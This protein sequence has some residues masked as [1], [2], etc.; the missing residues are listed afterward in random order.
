MHGDSGFIAPLR[1]ACPG[2]TAIIIHASLPFFPSPL[3]G[4]GGAGGARVG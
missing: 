2:M 3:V 1:G 4:E